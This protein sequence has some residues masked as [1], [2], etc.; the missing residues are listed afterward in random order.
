MQVFSRKTTR[1]TTKAIYDTP[2]NFNMENS[3]GWIKPHN[4]KSKNILAIRKRK[5]EKM[6]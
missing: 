5:G 4:I 3:Q 2:Q 6:F 1:Y